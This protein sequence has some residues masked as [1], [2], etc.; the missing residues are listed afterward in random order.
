MTLITDKEMRYHQMWMSMAEQAATMSHCDRRKV[1]AVIVKD[2]TIISTGW[3]GTP[4]GFDNC[5]EHHQTG[6]TLPH[7]IHAEGNAFDKLCRSGGVGA[8]DATLYVTLEPCLQC[9]IRTV[10]VGIKNVF[11]REQYRDHQGLEFL[12]PRLEVVKQI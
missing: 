10:N 1:G 11:Y 5:C 4:A 12:K 6:E 3:N 8:K 2:G 9:A 7:V